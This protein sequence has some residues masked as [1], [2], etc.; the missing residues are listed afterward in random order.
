MY[1]IEIFISLC[2]FC[3]CVF[4]QSLFKFFPH[5]GYCRILSRIPC[6]STVLKA[7]LGSDWLNKVIMFREI[8]HLVELLVEKLEQNQK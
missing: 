5:L 7:T 2:G 8:N 3:L 6:T 4:F 1:F